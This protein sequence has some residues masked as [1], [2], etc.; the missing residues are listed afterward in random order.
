MLE[1]AELV[2]ELTGSQSRIEFRPL[3]QDDPKQRKPD[4]TRARALLNW[5][6]RV[7]LREGLGKTIAYFSEVVANTAAAA[8][9]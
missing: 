8:K 4:T 6:A 7:P 3:P 5:E 2:L 1:L 9:G